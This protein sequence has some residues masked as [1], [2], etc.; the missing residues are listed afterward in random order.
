MIEEKG[1][2]AVVY[3]VWLPYGIGHFKDFIDS[4]LAHKN[5]LQHKLVIAFNGMANC[6]KKE[7]ED[8]IRFLKE[9]NITNFKCCYFDAGQDI[10]IYK[11]LADELK[12][13][14]YM[15]YL[16]SYSI[17]LCDHWL[18]HFVNNMKPGI[19]VV[20]ASGVYSSYFKSIRIKTWADLNSKISLTRKWKLLKYLIKLFLFHYFE[21]SQYP[22]PHIRTNAFF[23]KRSIFSSLVFNDKPGKLAAYAFENGRNSMTR[24]LFDLGLECVVVDKNGNGYICQNWYKSNVFWQNDQD[25]LVVSDN[26]TRKYSDANDTEKLFYQKLAWG[27]L[28]LN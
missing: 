16:N 7:S 11:S 24:Q 21:F 22:N 12:D 3:L 17:I 26:Q 5:T 23:I 6:E 15:L 27:E 13:F 19:G 9:K 8:Y 14:E 2:I 4:Y 28:F 18:S 25:N 20:G 1:N 10:K